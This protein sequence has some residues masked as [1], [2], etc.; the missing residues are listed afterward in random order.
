MSDFMKN[1]VQ[2]VLNSKNMTIVVPEKKEEKPATSLEGLFRPNYQRKKQQQRSSFET[3]TQ[4]P[5]QQVTA[6]PNTNKDILN[7]QLSSLQRVSAPR[8]Q[9]NGQGLNRAIGNSKEEAPQLIGKTRNQQYIWYFPVI[10]HRLQNLCKFNV[11]K[12]HA[13]GVITGI[14]NS[15]MLFLIDEYLQKS[16]AIYCEPC[17]EFQESKVAT[18]HIYSNDERQLQAMLKEIYNRLN[19]R[20]LRSIET[21]SVK[22]PSD[23]LRESL[24][25]KRGSSAAV[26]E[27]IH[28]FNAIALVERYYQQNVHVHAEFQVKEDYLIVEGDFQQV[29]SLIQHLKQEADQLFL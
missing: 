11:Q 18:L 24:G 8:T 23:F 26:L 7:H 16:Q 25:L 2:E 22:N 19:R 17:L 4:L 9:S 15:G 20:A 10:S 13:L 6:P 5:S 1:I 14:L 12:G 3:Q 21:Y 29:D 28:S 27:G